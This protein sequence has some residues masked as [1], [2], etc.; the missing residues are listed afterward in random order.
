MKRIERPMLALTCALVL[1]GCSVETPPAAGKPAVAAPVAC[2]AK[3]NTLNVCKDGLCLAM[4]E[5][6]FGFNPDNPGLNYQGGGPISVY[7]FRSF[8]ETPEQVAL[9]GLSMDK[10]FTRAADGKWTSLCDIDPALTDEQL[11]EK[12][13]I[14]P[15]PA[16]APVSN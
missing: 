11:R 1:I 4:G 10:A 8:S 12:F 14:A 13:G 5:H 15:A 16:P 7:V 2:P 9:A 6:T 3:I